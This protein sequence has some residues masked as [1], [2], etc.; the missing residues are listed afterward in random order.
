[1]SGWYSP[2]AFQ[3]IRLIPSDGGHA[4]DVHIGEFFGIV[5]FSSYRPQKLPKCV[6]KSVLWEKQPFNGKLQ[7][8]A[9]KWFKIS[10]INMFWPSFVEIHKA[11]VT[12]PMRDIQHEKNQCSAPTLGSLEWSHQKFYSV[13]LSPP[14]P[15]PSFVQIRPVSEEIH[16]NV[17]QTHNTIGLEKPT[18]N[19]TIYG[20]AFS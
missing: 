20:T 8:F 10:Q 7:N 9:T 16:E 5:Q 6:P 1:M 18:I 11:E 19:K 17:F 2:G 4:K 15:L 13:T 14:I 3:M 12:K